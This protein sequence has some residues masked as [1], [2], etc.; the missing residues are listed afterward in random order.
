MDASSGDRTGV[1]RITFQS[2]YN[3]NPNW[4][5]DG[6]KIAFTSMVK[7]N[8]Q[9]KIYNTE[10]RK[11]TDVTSGPGS[12]EEPTW[13]PDGQFL[14]Y[15]LTRGR[16]SSIH[17]RRVEGKKSRQLTFLPEGGVSPTWSPYPKR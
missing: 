10:T 15:R 3:D 1:K 7:G 2:R 12:K 6:D 16:Q 4:S 13:S 5:P 14:A 9:I 11:T 8:F 17:I